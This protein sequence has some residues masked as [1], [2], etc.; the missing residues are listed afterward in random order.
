MTE[1]IKLSFQDSDGKKSDRSATGATGDTGSIPRSGRSPGEW[2]GNPF[3]G[4]C[5]D[6]PMDRAGWWATVH[7]E[8]RVA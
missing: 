8:A 5:L 1:M 4:A 7:G 2:R 6:N 3:L